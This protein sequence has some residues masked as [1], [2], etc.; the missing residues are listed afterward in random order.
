GITGAKP[1]ERRYKSVRH[2]STAGDEKNKEEGSP[3]ASCWS[4]SMNH[5]WKCVF[6][7][8]IIGHCH[9]SAFHRLFAVQ[10]WQFASVTPV[11]DFSTQLIVS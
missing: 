8:E 9:E 4:C 5:W 11:I 7:H 1:A 6:D 3:S 10:E 2:R